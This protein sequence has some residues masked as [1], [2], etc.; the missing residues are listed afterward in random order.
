MHDPRFDL[1]SNSHANEGNRFGWVVEIDP[2]DATQ[3]PVK[4][5]ALGRFKHEGVAIV[6]GASGRIVAYM[7]DD[8]NNEYVYKFVSSGN[9]REM[10]SRGVSPL[11]E[12]QL[13][14]AKFA[15]DG[16]GTWLSLDVNRPEL[17]GKFK[18][19]AEVQVFARL[20]ADAVG[21][22]PMDRPE[23]TVVAPDGTVYCT[24]TNNK[25]RMVATAFNPTAPNLFGHI[26]RWRDSDD[27]L[28]DSFTWDLFMVCKDT[29][30][31]EAS[32]SAPDGLWADPDGR[33][34]I[35]T[36]GDQKEGMN[37]QLL[38][39]DT[40]TG[41]VRRLFS[42]VAGAEVTGFAVTPDRTTLFVNVQHPGDGDLNQTDF[43]RLGASRVPRDATI[44]IRRKDGGV[45]GS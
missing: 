11:D 17:R 42:S 36:D 40:H 44:A 10:R 34:F 14:V 6:E 38:V 8:S 4:R 43:P 23:W 24:L 28:G 16:T 12:G 25:S 30:G 13:Y 3:V 7:G 5:T 15:E 27:H 22:T 1:G 20:A 2:F 45:V 31:S 19:Q 9:W 35:A 32:F 29:H 37:N 33:L 26:V 41:D 18:N 21:A 39:A